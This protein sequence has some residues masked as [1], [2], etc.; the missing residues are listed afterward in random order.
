V[1]V[2]V[3]G[4]PLELP[5]GA[6]VEDLLERAGTDARRRGVAVAIDAEVVPRS[7]WDETVLAD[8]QAVELV[9]AMQGG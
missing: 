2:T 9:A 4:E 5:E 3:N 8:G 6:T 7:A 1:N